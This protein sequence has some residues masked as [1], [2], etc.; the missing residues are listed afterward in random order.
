MARTLL[1]RIIEEHVGRSYV[2]TVSV[3]VERAAEEFAREALAD[4]EFRRSMR[5]MIRTESKKLW[6]SLQK[7]PTRK[8]PRAKRR[9][10]ARAA[11]H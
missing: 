4:E 9:R 3:A 11:A 2:G 6:A 1:E 8:S 5:E 10:R 7:R